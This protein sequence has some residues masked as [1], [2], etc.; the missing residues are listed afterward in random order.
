MIS[1][2]VESVRANLPLK[3]RN[4]H[5]T[6]PQ[7]QVQSG[8]LKNDPTMYDVHV[9]APPPDGWDGT[10]AGEPVAHHMGM[11]WTQVWM[12]SFGGFDSRGMSFI[13]V[14]IAIYIYIYIHMADCFEFCGEGFH[15]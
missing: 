12:E 14:Y 8:A 13:H 11:L 4:P 9:G 1:V 7:M 5:S 10:A 3:V 15:C 6:L 2:W